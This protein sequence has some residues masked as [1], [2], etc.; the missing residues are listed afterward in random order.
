MPLER[1]T[2]YAAGVVAALVTLGALAIANFAGGE[3]AS[4]A[5]VASS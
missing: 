4:K 2:I 5:E 3:P 1:Q